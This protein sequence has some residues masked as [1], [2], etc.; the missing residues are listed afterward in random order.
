MWDKTQIETKTRKVTGGRECVLAKLKSKK[1][2]GHGAWHRGTNNKGRTKQDFQKKEKMEHRKW[3]HAGKKH[4]SQF[5]LP[6]VNE[7]INGAMYTTTGSP[8]WRNTTEKKASNSLS[9]ASTLW[10]YIGNPR[11]LSGATEIVNEGRVLWLEHDYKSSEIHIL[12]DFKTALQLMTIVQVV[13]SLF[14]L[15]WSTAYCCLEK[16]SPC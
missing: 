3:S 1:E 15:A 4:P 11:E 10:L 7:Q 2:Q 14:Y 6:P 8:G 16:L 12:G 5:G 9:T 13:L